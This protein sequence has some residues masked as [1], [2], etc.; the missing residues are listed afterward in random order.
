MGIWQVKDLSKLTTPSANRF[1]PTSYPALF[2]A[3]LPAQGSQGD[4]RSPDIPQEWAL[5]L[6]KLLRG[7][8]HSRDDYVVL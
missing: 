4:P 8:E 6:K 1:A 2:S 3:G 7:N 5:F